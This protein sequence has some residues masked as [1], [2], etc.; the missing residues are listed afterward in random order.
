MLEGAAGNINFGAQMIRFLWDYSPNLVPTPQMLVNAVCTSLN[1]EE[2]ISCFLLTK[3][4]GRLTLYR[5]LADALMGKKNGSAIFGRVLYSSIPLEL[6]EEDVLV[7]FEK[8]QGV[9][10]KRMLEIEEGVRPSQDMLVTAIEHRNI[11][12]L[13]V[14]L[15]EPG[16]H[17]LVSDELLAKVTDSQHQEMIEIF[18]GQGFTVAADGAS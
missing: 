3:R 16:F 4:T 6:T 14:L 17:E 15:P 12:A 8:W 18:Q 5:A 1:D 10:L 2:R 13:E 9:L 11:T 7:A